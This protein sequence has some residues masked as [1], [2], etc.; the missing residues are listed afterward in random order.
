M[1][2]I[3]GICGSPRNKATEYAMKEVLKSIEGREGI[4]TSIITLR[5]K[6]IA[7]CNG[8]GYCKKIRHGA[9]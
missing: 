4:E 3:L 6:K 5:G 1:A 7:P 9:V 8:C 2:K